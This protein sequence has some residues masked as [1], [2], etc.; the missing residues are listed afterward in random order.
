MIILGKISA[1]FGIR[2]W[3]KVHHF[4]DGS[5]V[6]GAHPFWWIGTEGAWSQYKLVECRPHGKSL[7]ALLRGVDSRN[8][9]EALSGLHVGLPREAMPKTEENE[10][11]W[12]DLLG[13]DVVNLSGESLGKVAD[14]LS[15]GAHEVLRACLDGTERLIPFVELFIKDIDLV[16]R[17]ICVDWQLD[18]D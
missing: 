14:F 11:Y 2:G 5:S 4:A 16:N 6:W 9:A 15:T 13:L 3:V 7:V 10:F 18:W 17:R 12:N 8:D 1:P